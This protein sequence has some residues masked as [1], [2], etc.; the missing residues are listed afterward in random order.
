MMRE[1]KHLNVIQILEIFEG[2]NNIY[3]VGQLYKGATLASLIQDKQHRF[4][5]KT[6]TNLAE[7]LIQVKII[8][9]GIRISRKQINNPQRY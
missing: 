2:D 6:V 1:V 3:C 7:K 5:E 8:Y 4:D 9:S